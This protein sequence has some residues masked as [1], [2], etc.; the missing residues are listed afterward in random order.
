MDLSL[1]LDPDLSFH[2][3]IKTQLDDFFPK[4][5]IASKLKFVSYSD[6]ELNCKVLINSETISIPKLTSASTVSLNLSA[7]YVL[8]NV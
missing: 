4:L 1:V 8:K 7:V 2:S 5:N 6:A 3:H